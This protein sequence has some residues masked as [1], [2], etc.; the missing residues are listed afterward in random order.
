MNTISGNDIKYYNALPVFLRYHV[1]RYPPITYGFGFQADI[2][3]RLLDEDIP[4]LQIRHQGAT[5]RKGKNATAL[6]MRNLLSVIHTF[7]EIV[8]RRLRRV[9][10]G[11]GMPRAREIRGED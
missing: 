11:K 4:D 5:D 1:M 8:I 3:T 2:V 10:Y 6:S 7:V 9:I